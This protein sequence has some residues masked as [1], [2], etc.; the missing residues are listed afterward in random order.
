MSLSQLA[1][2]HNLPWVGGRPPLGQY[3]AEV[4]RRR[5]FIFKMA[6]YRIRSNLENNRL[7]ILWI[8]LRPIVNA[9]IYGL[10]FGLIQTSAQK[11]PSYAASVVVGVFFFEL[12]QGCLLQGARAIRGNQNLVQSLAFPRMTL[13]LATWVEQMISFGIMLV[14]LVPILMLFGHFPNWGW[15]MMIPLVALYAMFNAGI[16]LIA[17]RLTVHVSDLVELLPYVSRILFYSSGVLFNVD[18]VLN[19]HPSLKPVFD[20]YPIYIVLKMA[21]H[22]LYGGNSF[23]AVFWLVLTLAAVVTL[24]FG[25]IFFWAAEERYGRE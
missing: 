22:Y 16:A 2:E 4:W 24:V 8:V 21:R 17:A 6:S 15:L 23:P 25:V 13:P 19:S 3:V 12:F 11:G 20:F 14:V 18:N 10:I 7:G 1:E 5:T 9:A